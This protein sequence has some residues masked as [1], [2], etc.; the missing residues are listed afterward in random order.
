MRRDPA[1]NI[2][3]TGGAG[4]IGSNLVDALLADA[5]EVVVIDNF[6]TGRME[7]LGRAIE[8]GA[9]VHAVDICDAGAVRGVVESTAP[10]VIV[11]LAAQVDVRR[12]VA[13]PAG[14]LQ[15]NIGGTVNVLAAAQGVG[16]RV[17]NVSTGGAIYGGGAVIPTP[18]SVV[19]VPEAPYGLSKLS[20]EGYVRL[21]TQLFGL[22]AA[23]ARLG[24]VYG[25][26]QDPHGEAG[27]IAIFCG[28][29]HEGRSPTVYGTGRQTRDY[30]YVDDVVAGLQALLARDDSSGIYN[31]GTGV[32][33]T[34]LDIVAG[35]AA[36]S[37]RPFDVTFMPPRRGEIEHSCLE[38]T[39]LAPSWD[40]L[41]R[42]HSQGVS[43]APLRGNA[44]RGRCNHP[45]QGRGHAPG[46]RGGRTRGRSRSARRV[47]AVQAS[48]QHGSLATQRNN[49]AAASGA[50]L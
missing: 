36:V 48:R 22:G 27:V 47:R 33:T 18:E 8:D 26:R 39:A 21:F 32:A 41:R 38:V 43:S 42:C 37:G 9:R 20:A 14:D 45:R 13:D 40:G 15:T 12:S 19:P 24:N 31:V 10:E 50:K 4:F 11:H 34:V 35:L 3:V 49:G 30:I 44:L 6:T 28:L 1:V 7:N 16:A 29:L 5:H 2:L 23:T 17:V 46:R 25:P